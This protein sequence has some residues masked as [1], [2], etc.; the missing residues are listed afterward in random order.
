[1]KWEERT[2]FMNLKRN[3]VRILLLVLGIAVLLCALYLC[4]PKLLKLCGYLVKLFLPFLLGYLFSVAVNPL[5]DTLQKRLKIPRGLSAVLVIVLIVGIL[6]G[7]LT[8]AIWKIVDE[9][10]MIYR[11]FPTIYESVQNSLHAIGD[12]WSVVYVGLPT[13]IQDALSAF[14]ESVSDKAAEFINVKS[15]PVVDYAGNFAK[16][17]PSVFIA[18]IAFILSSYFMVSENKRVMSTVQRFLNPKIVDRLNLIRLEL[19]KYLGGYIKAQGIIMC[20]AFVIIFLGLSILDIQ[21]GLIIAFGIAF[22]DALPFFG[23]GLALW[24]WS[25]VAFLNGNFRVGIGL[26]IIYIAVALM[27]HFTEPKLVSSRVGMNPI[28]TLM[29]MYV[30]YRTLS[31]GGM[32]LGPVILML[33]ISFYKAGV[34]DAP[35]RLLKKMGKFIKEQY[36]SFKKFVGNLIGSEWNE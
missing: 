12:R 32:I 6:G 14:G 27:R 7:T 34:F 21:Y 33:I 26:I 2:D 23:S 35:I 10:Q 5:A 30:G 11:Q 3:W 24:P 36:L 8:F 4:L 18:I 1:M 9:A 20:I 15:T 31:I 17:L 16:A 19:K 29:A 28:L 13:N 25:L 22:L